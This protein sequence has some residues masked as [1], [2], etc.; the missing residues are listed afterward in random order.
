[1]TTNVYFNGAFYSNLLK[2]DAIYQSDYEA[3]VFGRINNETDEVIGDADGPKLTTKTNII[4]FALLPILKPFSLY[5]YTG[6][7]NENFLKQISSLV[8]KFQIVGWYKSRSNTPNS[9]MNLLEKCVCV[10]LCKMNNNRNSIILFIL[11]TYTN[12]H[13]HYQNSNSNSKL[14]YIYKNQHQAFVLNEQTNEFKLNPIQIKNI[15]TLTSGQ[16]KYE[17][18]THYANNNIVNVTTG[19]E[20]SILDN[21]NTICSNVDVVVGKLQK[22]LKETVDD[23]TRQECELNSIY[24]KINENN[25]LM[26]KKQQQRSIQNIAETIQHKQTDT[27]LV[28]PSTSTTAAAANNNTDTE[29]IYI[30]DDVQTTNEDAPMPPSY[31]T[32]MNNDLN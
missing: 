16:F 5:S 31:D 29:D 2:Y 4:C 13:N 9:I 26:K 3:L 17:N 28:K 32:L 7:I 25:L 12:T 19:I 20:K 1:M 22:E 10:N 18:Q 11:N 14:N 23:L 6:Q 21:I 27:I 15:G 8:E 24:K 30:I